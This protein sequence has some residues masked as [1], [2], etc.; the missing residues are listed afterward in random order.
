MRRGE[1]DLRSILEADPDDALAHRRLGLV[2][3]R[4]G[5]YDE[6]VRELERAIS[7]APSE[8]EY[9]Q[10]LADAYAASGD[11]DRAEAELEKAVSLTAEPARKALA[12]K[13]LD[14]FRRQR[15][16]QGTDPRA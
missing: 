15:R 4:M 9:R 5:R 14:Y 8:P 2:L 7:L 13:V 16:A 11:P 3:T 1:R 6:G 10:E 12:Q